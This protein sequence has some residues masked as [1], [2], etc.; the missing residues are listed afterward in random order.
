MLSLR[1]IGRYAA[2]LALLF[3]TGIT[4]LPAFG[5][6]VTTAALSGSVVDA[7]GAS[8]AGATVVAVHVPSGTTY[9]TVANVDG[10]YNLP[11][12]RVGGPYTVTVTFVGFQSRTEENVYLNLAQNLKL[13]FSL[14]EQVAALGEVLVT[15]ETDDVLNADRTGASTSIS[16][17]QVRLMPTI[18]R[19]TR[20]LTRLDPRSDGNLSFGGRNWLFNNISLDGSYF[21]NPY[22]LDAP[23]PGG[24]SNAQPVP[25]D[26]IEQVQVSVAPFDVREGGF[27]GAGINQVTKSGTN[28]FKGT[29]YLF[30]RNDAMVGNSVKGTTVFENPELSFSQYGFSIGGPIKK[31]KLFFF[32][33][34]ELERREDPGTNFRASDGTPGPGESRVSASVMDQIRNRMMDVYDY[35]TGP[36]QDYTWNTDNNKV[37]AKLDYNINDRNTAS[38]RYNY[39]D[40]FREQGPH[41]FVLSFGGRGPNESSLPFRNAGYRINNKLHSLAFELNSRGDA[42]ANR[43]F[44][45]ANLFRDHRDPMSVDFPTIEIAEGGLTYTTVGHEP[46]SIHNI[47]DQ[48]VLQLTNNF[49]LFRGKHVFTVGV[50]YE[51]FSFFNSFNIFRHGGFGPLGFAI[52]TTSFTSLADFFAATTPGTPGFKDFRTMTGTGPFKGENTDVGQFSVYAQDEFSVNEKLRLTYGLRVDMPMYFTDPVENPYSTGLTLLDENDEPETLDQAELAGATP[53]FSPRVGFNY[54]V[55]GDRSLQLRGGAGLFTGRVPFVWIGNVISNPGFNPNLYPTQTIVTREGEDVD[56]TSLLGLPEANSVLTTSFD[57]NMMTPDFKWPQVF[58]VDFAVDAQLPSDVLGSLEVVYSKD[59]NSVYV[60]NADLRTPVRTLPDGRPYF[61][62]YGAAELNAAWPGEGAGA[63]V[64]DNSDEGYN[65][66]ITGSLRKA[67]SSNLRA[68]LAYTYL[69]ARNLFKSTEIASVL[70]SESP[71]QG[72]PNRPGLSYSEFGYPHRIIGSATYTHSWNDRLSTDIG[73]FAEIAQGNTFLGAG[74]NRYSYTYAGDVNGDGIGT[75]D[76]IY[77]PKDAESTSEIR[78]VSTPGRTADQQAAAFEKFIEQDDYLSS[79]RGEIAERFGAVNPWFFNVDLRILQNIGFNVGGKAQKVQVSLDIMNLPNLISSD[80]GVRKVA[81][82]AATTP[83]ALAGF[84]PSGAPQFTFS[85]ATETFTDDYS[86]LSRWQMQ[87]GVR[88]IFD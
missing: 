74:G 27:T 70:F 16:A 50:N 83:L 4:T 68:S 43:F 1:P 65:Y 36:Y 60:R 14:A 25:Y 54:D 79:H 63:Y 2:T 45:S 61:G 87:L 59:I 12:L 81:T 58:T 10:F 20:D 35:E 11:N 15:A 26:A 34:A 46:F 88:Y 84:S 66:T 31:D 56:P 28:Q 57:T 21:N 18:K 85:G 19:S 62:G 80:W 9:G 38:L 82:P 48:D 76:L 71:V 75:N 78:F 6:G 24:Q 37:L 86:L 41:P 5:Q 47:L 44:A 3:L 29:A 64:I 53:L 32:V 55:Y 17:E 22:G 23:E 77:I 8:L 40:A 51:S 13:D 49:S 7:A 69:Q 52:G 30:T 33:N 73:L 39:L 72:D 67:F 42:W